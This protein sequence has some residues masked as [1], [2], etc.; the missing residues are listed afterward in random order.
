MRDECEEWLEAAR[1]KIQIAEHHRARLDQVDYPG[2]GLV[3]V[4]VQASLEGVLY[5][6]TAATDQLANALNLA[7][8]LD[9]QREEINLSAALDRLAGRRRLHVPELGSVVG[10]LRV[11]NDA[12]LV[13]DARRLRNKATHCRYVKRIRGDEI[14]IN[15]VGGTYEGSRDLKVYCNSVVE[16]LGRLG[17]LLDQVSEALDGAVVA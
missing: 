4:E 17:R 14:R 5:C 9:L 13:A 7:E 11:W 6:F 12:P 3:S 10:A 16:H 2:A 15:R 8:R 1:R